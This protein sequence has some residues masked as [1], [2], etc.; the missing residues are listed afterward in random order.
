MFTQIFRNWWMLAVRGV[1]GIVF[2]IAAL[3]WPESAML[4]LV[5]LFGAF[6]MLDG[7]FAIA[8]S[9][10]SQGY[11]EH[12][13]GILFE[14]L[15]GIIIGI[16][17]FV[18]PNITALI[19]LYFISAWA[20]ITGIFETVAAIKFRRVIPG[21]WTMIINGIISVLLGTL[22]FIFPAAGEVSIAWMIGIFAITAGIMELIFAFRLRSLLHMSRTVI[23]I[24][25]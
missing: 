20:V 6:V 12:W 1:I 11:F 16:L 24:N 9:I 8:F 25:A 18:W 14:G 17:T 5:L 23:R 4:A 21:E 10:A 15:T 19:L 3:I 13:W 7:I 22:L 2:G